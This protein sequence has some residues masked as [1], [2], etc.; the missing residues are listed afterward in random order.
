MKRAAAMRALSLAAALLAPVGDAEVAVGS[1]MVQI[2]TGLGLVPKFDDGNP[3][4]KTLLPNPAPMSATMPDAIA[5]TTFSQD[6]VR[7]AAVAAVSAAAGVHAEAH[8]AL[9]E[10]LNEAITAGQQAIVQD[11]QILKLPGVDDP[12][13]RPPP[14]PTINQMLEIAGRPAQNTP[15]TAHGPEG[16]FDNL[17]PNRIPASPVTSSV[18]TVAI[19]MAASDESH[20]Q[21]PI[22]VSASASSIED[23]PELLATGNQMHVQA[24]A[25]TRRVADAL[26]G[27]VNAEQEAQTLEAKAAELRANASLLLQRGAAVA[28]QASAEIAKTTAQTALKQ[29]MEIE[30]QAESA[31]IS[32]ASYRAQANSATKQ[33]NAAVRNMYH[34]LNISK[35]K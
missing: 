13:L 4:A 34:A 11:R 16:S 3:L 27:A 7:S 17:R 15:P 28:E 20:P 21:V 31:E 35:I 24:S 29:M 14:A 25:S 26:A 10:R 22:T 2:R 18:A 5:M 12:A 19:S 1:A 6:P 8:R 33:A 9:Q 30:Q 32:A 23:L